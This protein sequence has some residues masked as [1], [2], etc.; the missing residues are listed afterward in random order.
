MLRSAVRQTDKYSVF[1]NLLP[2]LQFEV[3][4]RSKGRVLETNQQQNGQH[5]VGT[6][7][8]YTVYREYVT[9]LSMKHFSMMFVFRPLKGEELTS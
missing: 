3:L 4:L 7:Y 8:V 1:I 5:F 9:E 6:L 2:E